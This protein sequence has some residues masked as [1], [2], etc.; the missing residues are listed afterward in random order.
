[1][2]TVWIPSL[3]RP[4]AG[5]HERVTA[6]GRTLGEVIAA[7]DKAYP[8]ISARLCAGDELNPS[9]AAWIDGRIARGMREP[10]GD[11]SEVQFLPA[12]SGG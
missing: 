9:L 8:G 10:V 6:S 4:L 1:M 3:L 7:L 5:G 11:E 12:V 2:A